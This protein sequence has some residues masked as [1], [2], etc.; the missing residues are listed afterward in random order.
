MRDLLL[1]PERFAAVME[2][3][4]IGDDSHVVAYAETDHSGAARLWWALHYY[5]HDQ[6][7]VLNEGWTKWVAEGRAVSTDIPQPR[8]PYSLRDLVPI[9]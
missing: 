8:Q 6:V 9:G 1:P 3:A 7:A 5:G 2:A 4:G